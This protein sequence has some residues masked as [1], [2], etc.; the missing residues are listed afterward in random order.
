MQVLELLDSLFQ[1]HL[2]KSFMASTTFID[3]TT[4]IVADWLNDVNTATY[5]TVPSLSTTVAAHTT[6]IAG[7][8]GSGA[9]TDIT[10]LDSPELNSATATTQSPTDNSDKIATTAFVTT[11]VS[12]ISVPAQIQPISAAVSGNAM[13]ISAGALSLDFRSTTLGSGTVTRVSGTPASLVIPAGAT[14]ATQNG[15]QSDLYVLAL[16]NAGTIE[17][18]VLSLAGGSFD[19]SEQGV[20]SSSAISAS[21]T[22]PGLYSTTARTNVAFRVIGVIRSTQTTAGQWATAPTLV[23]GAGGNALTALSSLGYG[24][25]WQNVTASRALGTTYYNATGKPIKA[26]IYTTV[27]AGAGST[28]LATIN[29][30]TAFVIGA[31]YSPGGNTYGVGDVEVPPGASYAITTT[32]FTTVVNWQELR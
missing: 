18:A 22:A 5:N 15:V 9:N 28:I 32:G 1:E 11:A 25:S 26:K 31:S 17:L 20:T 29:G 27:A 2:S 24:Q 8:A 10:S 4:L 6:Q 19:L 3:G 7:K 13:T 14:L 23:Q 30:G 21:T 16:N 12:A